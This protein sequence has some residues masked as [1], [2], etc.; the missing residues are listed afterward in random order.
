MAD[1]MI[2]NGIR[3]TEIIE[4]KFRSCLLLLRFYTP[5]NVQTAPVHALLTDLLTASSADEPGLSALSRKL[6]ALYAADFSARLM[7]CGDAAALSFSASWLDDRFALCGEDITG[8]ML[9]LVTGC[10][11]RPNLADGGFCEP[12]FSVCRQNLLDDI[13]CERNDRRLYAMQRA[14]ELCFAGEPAAIP[15][16][17][18]RQHA[19]AVTPKQAFAVWEQLLHTA[20]IDIV[21][22]LPEE[23]PVRSALESAF[24]GIP[25]CPVPVPLSALTPLRDAPLRCTESMRIS[26]S[27]LVLVYQ[28]RNIA[29]DVLR[30]LN[31]ILGG[32]N[33]SLL[34]LNVREARSLC[35]YCLSSYSLLKGVLS[36]DCGVQTA[37]LPAAE[38]A[39]REQIALLQSG[40][41]PDSMLREAVLDYIGREAAQENTNAGIADRI[42]DGLMRGDTRSPEETAAALAAVTKAQI[43]EAA[44]QLTPAAVYILRAEEAENA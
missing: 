2:G 22:I 6:D 31:G 40:D 30:M 1:P 17:G 12:E 33:N 9:K 15:P 7:L 21:C 37:D 43:T 44:R 3:Y 23:K 36:V 11:L 20:P 13:D 35:Y 34:F 38:E 29:P 5:R 10:L 26:Q 19:A 8:G 27:K 4:P 32:I 16:F 14:S 24:S 41:F 28:F 42:A 39:V 25:R 18:D